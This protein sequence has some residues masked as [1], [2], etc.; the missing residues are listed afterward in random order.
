MELTIT[1]VRHRG[2][3]FEPYIE[4]VA[5]AGEAGCVFHMHEDDISAEGAVLFADALTQQARRWRLRPPDMPRGPRIPIT[6][7]LRAHMEEGVAIVVD[8]RADAIHYVVREDLITQHA[9]EV[10]TGSQS[11]RSPHW[12]RLPARY[13]V[14]SKAS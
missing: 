11:E 2:A 12:M 5:T 3:H 8:D 10:I 9:G 4:D 13:V 1:I 6:M 7:E 14:R